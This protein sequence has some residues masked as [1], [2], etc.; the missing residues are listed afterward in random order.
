MGHRY[1]RRYPI[2]ISRLAFGVVIARLLTLIAQYATPVGV[3][4]AFPGAAV[5][6][7]MLAAGIDHALVAQWTPPAGSASVD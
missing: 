4:H 2:P 5:A 7:T 1:N 3:A 6:G